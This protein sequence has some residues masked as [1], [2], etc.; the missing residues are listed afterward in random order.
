MKKE[1]KTEDQRKSLKVVLADRDFAI[2]QVG[3]TSAMFPST[4]NYQPLCVKGIPMLFTHDQAQAVAASLR[5]SDK[6]ALVT[7]IELTH[8]ETP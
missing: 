8:K 7:R 3:H 6:A 1:D 4:Y 2:V 5:V